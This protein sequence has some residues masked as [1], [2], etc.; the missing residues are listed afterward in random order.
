MATANGPG[1]E[2]PREKSVREQRL[3]RRREARLEAIR[4]R[5][6]HNRTLIEFQPDAVELEKQAVPG[7]ARWT[8]YT[9][10]AL[11]ISVVAWSCWAEVDRIVVANGKLVTVSNPFI[12]QSIQTAPI[13]KLNFKFGDRVKAG[14]VMATLDPTFPESDLRSLKAKLAGYDASLHRLQLERDTKQ[15][16]VEE[17]QKNADMAMEYQF[18]LERKQE[19]RAKMNEFASE[20]T[21]LDI[22]VENNIKNIELNVDAV[23]IHQ[24]VLTKYQDLY[25]KSAKSEIESQQP[26]T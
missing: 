7:G 2:E 20:K 12:V 13:R 16:S 14:E 10:V 22:Q 25:R 5:S 8:L 3:E 1:V 15:F 21:K 18:W 23:E 9:V 11:L 4:K 17:S 26:T 24:D 6:N 19:Y